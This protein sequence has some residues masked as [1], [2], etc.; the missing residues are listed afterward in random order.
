MGIVS[1]SAIH[2]A[3][4][5][6]ASTT[7]HYGIVRTLNQ[8]AANYG[9]K[10]MT[11]DRDCEHCKHHKEETYKGMTF[12]AC[13]VWEC[14]YEPERGEKDMNVCQETEI[15]MNEIEKKLDSIE[16]RV[17]SLLQ[18]AKDLNREVDILVARAKGAK[19]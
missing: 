5:T 2:G 14:K 15:K 6:N 3:N 17:N 7:I 10:E 19:V 4:T 18:N 11:K 1:I 12:K 13:E 16:E 9:R 8:S